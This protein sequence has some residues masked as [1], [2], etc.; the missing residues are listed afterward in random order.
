MLCCILNL[1]LMHYDF[2]SQ[3]SHQ[4]EQHLQEIKKEV[5]SS[6]LSL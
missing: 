3:M 5:T 2:M 6:V 1:S 4:M